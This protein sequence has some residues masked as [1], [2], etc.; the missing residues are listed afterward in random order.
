MVLLQLVYL[1]NFK[2]ICCQYREM[3]LISVFQPRILQAFQIYL[4]TLISYKFFWAFYVCNHIINKTYLTFSLHLFHYWVYSLVGFKFGLCHI[5]CA[6]ETPGV[7]NSRSHSYQG[8]RQW[9]PELDPVP[10]TWHYAYNSS[11]A[12]LLEQFYN[13]QWDI[14]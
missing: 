5:G 13:R 14:S 3:L 4:L 6:T 2:I 10:A 12:Q 7:L 8:Q 11:P 1:K 9:P